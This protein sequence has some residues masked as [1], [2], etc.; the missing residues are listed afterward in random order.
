MPNPINAHDL[1]DQAAKLIK[2]IPPQRKE[3]LAELAEAIKRESDPELV[4]ICTHNSRRSHFAQIAM[5][6]VS[7]KYRLGIKTYSGGT[8]ATALNLRALVTLQK[9]GVEI[10]QSP[11]DKSEGN[12]IY[13]FEHLEGQ[14]EIY[15]KKY[16]DPVNPQKDFIAIMV[17]SDA[18]N[19][20]PNVEGAKYRL[21]IPY[22]DPKISDG[23]DKERVVYGASLLQ[24][25]SEMLYVGQ[26]VGQQ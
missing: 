3:V 1:L 24:I 9:M 15:S 7:D 26:K 10:W 6:L 5:K 22:E 11:Q 20:C 4:F 18:D 13:I 14:S 25:T 16:S 17:C 23:T 12:P 2:E 8:E 19:A 21:A